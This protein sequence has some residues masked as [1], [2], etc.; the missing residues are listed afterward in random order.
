[1]SCE[2]GA[3]A[4]PGRCLGDRGRPNAR[5]KRSIWQVW[6]SIFSEQKKKHNEQ[7]ENTHFSTNESGE[8]VELKQ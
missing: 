5:L 1:M 3:C 2:A 6:G 4:L 7:E 8:I